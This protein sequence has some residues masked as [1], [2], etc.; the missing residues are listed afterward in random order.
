MAGNTRT[1]VVKANFSTLWGNRI[2][3]GTGVGR[4]DKAENERILPVQ[5]GGPDFM[6]LLRLM[7]CPLALLQLPSLDDKKA[8]RGFAKG[9]SG[10][11]RVKHA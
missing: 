10:Q 11:I 4:D 8:G 3:V 5:N 1:S 9:T 7:D 2:G 6:E